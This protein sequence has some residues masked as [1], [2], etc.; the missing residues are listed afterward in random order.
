MVKIKIWYYTTVDTLNDE[1][2][3]FNDYPD[4]I[5]HEG[6]TGTIRLHKDNFE[7]VVKNADYGE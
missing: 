2:A 4:D 6:K 3:T 5:V 7:S 1:G